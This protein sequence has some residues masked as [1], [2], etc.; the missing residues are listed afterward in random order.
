MFRALILSA[1]V[2]SIVIGIFSHF[3]ETQQKAMKDCLRNHSVS[4]CEYTLNR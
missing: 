4:T 2:A 3:H 1:A